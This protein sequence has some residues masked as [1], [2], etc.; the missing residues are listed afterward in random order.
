M[1]SEILGNCQAEIHAPEFY[2]DGVVSSHP[3]QGCDHQTPRRIA[4]RLRWRASDFQDPNEKVPM[5]RRCHDLKDKSTPRREEL[6]K[7]IQRQ[8]GAFSLDDYRGFRN[9]H[10]VV[11][12]D[13][14]SLPRNPNPVWISYD[15]VTGEKS[16]YIY[17]VHTANNKKLC[18]EHVID[19]KQEAAIEVTGLVYIA[20][21]LNTPYK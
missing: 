9:N 12:A 13:N 18:E 3:A 11:Y 8:K 5:H 14:G 15:P 10:D 16:V 2:S 21:D 7:Q 20:I 1:T 19:E 17:P 6:L 4:S